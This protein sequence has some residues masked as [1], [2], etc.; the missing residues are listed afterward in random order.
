MKNIKIYILI[1]VLAVLGVFTYLAFNKSKKTDTLPLSDNAFA[2][3]DT[4]S[5]DKLF[6]SSKAGVNITLKRTPDG[7]TLNDTFGIRK[8][9]IA[10]ILQAIHDVRIQKTINPAGRN[11]VIR[12]LAVNGIKIEV[13]AN[14]ERAKAFYL[15]GATTDNLA[16]YVIMENSEDP[17]ILHIP[18]FNGYLTPRFDPRINEWRSKQVF[19]SSAGSLKQ[20]SIEH[21]KNPMENILFRNDLTMVSM[22]GIA[23]PDTARLKVFRNAFANITFERLVTTDVQSITDSLNLLT[24]DWKIEVTDFNP[25]KS[26]AIV[27]YNNPEMPDRMLGFLGKRKELVTVQHG[28]FD[29]ILFKKSDFIRK[30]K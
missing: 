10:A 24:P 21:V 13:Y 25:K 16:N 2:V 26:N 22:D 28:Q 14:G 20:V 8:D 19:E 6:F 30:S 1:A 27:L 4:A 23:N 17:Y 29:K 15:G 7:W 18:G 3:A 12:D 5:V 9:H 11:S